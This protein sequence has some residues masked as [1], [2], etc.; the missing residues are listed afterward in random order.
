ML[1]AWPVRFHCALCKEK[2]VFAVESNFSCT[3][4]NQRLNFS[5]K[6][7]VLIRPL[8]NIPLFQPGGISNREVK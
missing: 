3:P 1:T 7:A 2:K 5:I 8:L 6:Y 4:G